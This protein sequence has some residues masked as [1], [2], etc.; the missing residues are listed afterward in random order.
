MTAAESCRSS[1]ARRP[2]EW[3][4]CDGGSRAG[5]AAVLTAIPDRSVVLLDGLVASAAPGVVG[6]QGRRLR[7]VVLVHMP[8]GQGP[9]AAVGA[10]H[11]SDHR[12]DR[13]AGDH[14]SLSPRRGRVWRPVRTV[15]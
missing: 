3:P 15:R 1:R 12:A 14:A 2:G 8:L 13:R 11:R 9:T 10:D 7:L 4:R 6:A 5:L